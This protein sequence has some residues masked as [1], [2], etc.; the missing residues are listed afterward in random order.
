MLKKMGFD[1]LT[2][3]DGCEAIEIFK[4]HQADIVGI[5]LDLTM[6]HKDGAEAFREIHKLNPDVKVILSS[7]Y[8][9][10]AATQQFVGKGL[11]GFIQKPYVSEGLV[12]KIIEVMSKDK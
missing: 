3:E 7:G 5:L 2:A 1:V 12:K 4:E 11:A 9:E 10:Q 6:P 8:N